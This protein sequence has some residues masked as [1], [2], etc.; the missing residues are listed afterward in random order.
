MRNKNKA[1]FIGLQVALKP[2]NMLKVQVIGR[3]IKNQ[4]SGILQK[5]LGQQN[6]GPLAAA[7]IR[8]ISIQTNFT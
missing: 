1:I 5:Q 2:F 7:Q 6:F 4:N 8:H 3:L